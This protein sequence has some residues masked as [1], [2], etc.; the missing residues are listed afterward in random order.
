MFWLFLYSEMIYFTLLFPQ[1]QWST[2]SLNN[3]LKHM[4]SVRKQHK[5]A[6][7]HTGS[8]ELSL[9]EPHMTLSELGFHFLKVNSL[10]PWSFSICICWA[11]TVIK[12]QGTEI[13]LIRIVPI[14][15][16]SPSANSPRGLVSKYWVL[17]LRS[18]KPILFSHSEL[19]L[20]IS[21]LCSSLG[22]KSLVLVNRAI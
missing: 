20:S 1:P 15:G 2:V 7:G 8:S 17:Y 4:S 9:S 11:I 19:C 18:S 12:E 21:S 10:W 14:P 16:A 3:I 5:N 22:L 6:I 13:Q